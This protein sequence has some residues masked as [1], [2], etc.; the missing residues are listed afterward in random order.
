MKI[1][2]GKFSV[3]FCGK[4]SIRGNPPLAGEI[5]TCS[6]SQRKIREQQSLLTLIG[7]HIFHQKVRSL[8]RKKDH[9][10]EILDSFINKDIDYGNTFQVTRYDF[11]G[12]ERQTGYGG[13]GGLAAVVP[14]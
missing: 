2:K 13:G 1:R 14:S 7:T 8:I 4:F 12:R 6:D 9:I 11:E 5:K 3:P 10:V